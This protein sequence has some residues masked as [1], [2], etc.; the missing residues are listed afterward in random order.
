[1]L[2]YRLS[3]IFVLLV[4]AS[5]SDSNSP[6]VEGLVCS[7]LDFGATGDGVTRD[8]VALQST[9]DECLNGIVRIPPGTYLTG[10]LYPRSNS[11]IRL[12]KDAHLRG[13]T[14]RDDWTD[15]ALLYIDS[16]QGVV[17]E[18]EG[19]LEG[20]GPYWW[21]EFKADRWRPSNIVRIVD[22][23]NVTVRGV[24]L[25]DSPSWTL[26]I[27]RSEHVLIDGVR[28]RNRVAVYPDSPNTDGIDIVSSRHIEIANCDIE[29]SDDGIVIKTYEGMGS[30]YDVDVH[31]CA[32]AG[33]AHGLH[34]GLETWE[35][36]R[37]VTFR[38]TVIRATRE[39]NPGTTYFAAVSLVSM[40]GANISDV[41]VER[42]TV[43]ATQAPIFIR[44][45]GGG[46]YPTNTEVEPGSLGNITIRDY[47]VQ[48]ATRASG[49]FGSPERALGAIRLENIS[50]ESHKGGTAQD[51]A[52]V[53]D[54]A[55]L[56]Y[57]PSPRFIKTLPAYGFY[58]RDVEGVVETEGIRVTT[59][60]ELEERPQI[61]LERADSVDLEGF[62]VDATIR[63]R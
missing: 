37:D 23:D 56:R 51:A 50:I 32:L 2:L 55:L 59:T 39:S 3:I 8:T 10:T 53:I 24:T 26:D 6:S 54:D 21:E 42:V 9:I 47:T 27:L 44:V 15:N 25:R 45:Q 16:V 43:E 60:A 40:Y 62:G 7:P 5:C 13:T 4:A 30:V 11:T 19:I 12:D 46:G 22:S 38:D 49:I 57:Y 18:G 29:T 20:N 58:F 52:R 28:I 61:L 34:I 41:T 36:I 17:I 48:N 31:G 35:D 1:M 33:W 63:Y 14:E